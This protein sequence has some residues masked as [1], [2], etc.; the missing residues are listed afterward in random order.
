[1]DDDIHISVSNAE[2]ASLL[3]ENFDELV[4]RVNGDLLGFTMNPNDP[5]SVEAAVA[6]SE[7][8]IDC[9]LRE[10]ADDA[11]LQ[12]LAQD[13]KRRFRQSIEAQARQ[14]SR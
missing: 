1:M 13:I 2:A 10:F 8:R 5:I 14:A 4:A 9:H 11:A 7:Q 12:S 3:R 6:F